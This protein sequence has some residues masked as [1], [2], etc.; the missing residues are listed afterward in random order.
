MVEIKN[1]TIRYD[2]LVILDNVT[3]NVSK[4]EIIHILGPNG[5]GKT[6]LIKVL[7]GFVKPSEGKVGVDTKKIG[8]LPQII[9]VNNNFPTTVKEVIYSGFEKQNLFISKEDT[10]LIKSWLEKM[11]I[12]SLIDKQFS[13]LSGGQRQRV[14]LVRAIISNPELLVLDEPTSALDPEFRKEFYKIIDELHEKG[15]TILNI[16]HDLDTD[17]VSCKHKILYLDRSVKYF[18]TYCDF[19]TS[20]SK[21]EHHHV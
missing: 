1:V 14:L 5:S 3:F 15:M 8:Y 19:D 4:G 12:N 10:A 9:K 21:K 13:E 18:G 20:F 2:N 7:L 11:E 17:Y 16:T 6:T